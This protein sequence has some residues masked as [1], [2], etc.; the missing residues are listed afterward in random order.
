M[1]DAQISPADTGLPGPSGDIV[2]PPDQTLQQAGSDFQFPQPEKDHQLKSP[3]P[4]PS[5]V[6]GE[7]SDEQKESGHFE[8]EKN[9]PN[10]KIHR[11]GRRRHADLDAIMMDI[12]LI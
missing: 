6:S 8:D 12:K 9:V 3:S 4:F 1:G 11:L 2:A 5:P 10:A 7:Q